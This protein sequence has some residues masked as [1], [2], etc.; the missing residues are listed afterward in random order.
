VAEFA[1]A[2]QAY[3]DDFRDCGSRAY[4]TRNFYSACTKRSRRDLRRAEDLVLHAL[5]RS[6]TAAC[7][8]ARDRL[9][10]VIAHV[11]GAIERAVVAFDRTNNALLKKRT[12][13][14]P[15]PKELF[16]RAQQAIE[17]DLPAARKLS[18]AIDAGC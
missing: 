12:Y 17:E 8:R 3:W 13:S 15:S 2:A 5:D 4:P 11:G 10:G 9:R 6:K 16:P 18:G 1:R 14:G 7:K